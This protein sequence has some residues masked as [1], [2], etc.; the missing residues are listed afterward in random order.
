MRTVT[1]PLNAGT[2]FDLP[3]VCMVTGAV[4]GVQWYQR[5]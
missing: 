2:R 1:F 5:A 4:S 3:E